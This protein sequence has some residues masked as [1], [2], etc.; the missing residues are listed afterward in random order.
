MKFYIGYCAPERIEMPNSWGAAN[1]TILH[2]I[3]EEYARG[4]R[5]DWQKNLMEKFRA[6]MENPE[7]TDAV[8]K[9]AKGVKTS[10]AD[11]IGKSRRYC[12]KCPFARVMSDGSTVFCKAMGKTTQEF[13]GSP[14][15]MISD[16]WKLAKVIFDNDFNP[17]DDLKVIGVEHKFEVTFENGVST[18]GYIDLVSEIDEETIEIRDYKSAKRVP[19]DRDIDGGWVAKDVQMQLYYAV[20][21]YCCDNN[22]PPFSNKYKNILVTIHFLRKTPITM[23]YTPSDYHRILRMLKKAYDDIRAVEKPLP[24]GMWGRN[25]YW[26]CNYCNKDACNKACLDLHGKTREELAS[27]H[28]D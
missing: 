7:I 22:I 18:L 14:K 12:G 21:K 2:E 19:S 3:F 6:A 24:E 9:F 10:L 26:I 13:D 4:E 28:S 5:R 16:T 8:F 11:E 25:H 1:G 15:K 27:E 20:A 23:V 17:I